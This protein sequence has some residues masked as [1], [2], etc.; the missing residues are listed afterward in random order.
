[1]S[2]VPVNIFETLRGN[3]SSDDEMQVVKTKDPNQKRIRPKKNKEVQPMQPL[4]T[5]APVTD[6]KENTKKEKLSK[7][8]KPDR[9]ISNENHNGK[10]KQSGTGRGKEMRWEWS[11]KSNW[12]TYK[13]EMKEEKVEE[14]TQ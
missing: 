12:G 11:G 5:Q 3:E 1:M 10:D 9:K 4:A 6:S 7:D 13:D 8:Q 14:E 2:K